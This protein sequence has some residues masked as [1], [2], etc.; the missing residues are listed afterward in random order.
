[1]SFDQA[2]R[3]VELLARLL[4]VLVVVA[5]HLLGCDHQGPVGAEALAEQLL[6]ETAVV[7]AD[8]V[9]TIQALIAEIDQ[10]GGMTSAL[11]AG[12]PNTGRLE[13]PLLRRPRPQGR[14]RAA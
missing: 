8:V 2:G 1:M 6:Q 9:G 7:S 5:A 14:G 11:D 3:E 13:R 10:A 12:I 4:A